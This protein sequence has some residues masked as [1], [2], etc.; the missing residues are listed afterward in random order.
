L[1]SSGWLQADPFVDLQP[2]WSVA[3]DYG[4]DTSFIIKV[5]LYLIHISMEYSYLFL[6]HIQ[7]SN[8]TQWEKREKR[9]GKKGN[10]T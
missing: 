9:K 6:M 2:R 3:S 10:P 5:N 1:S 8:L 7:Y 4:D